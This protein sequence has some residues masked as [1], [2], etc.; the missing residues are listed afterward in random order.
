MNTSTILHELQQARLDGEI[1][2]P[3]HREYDKCRRVWNAT[4]DCL[5]TAI[6]RAKSA[7]DVEKTVTIAAQQGALLAVRGGGH[8]LPG[9][10]TCDDGI[11]L[12]LSQMNEIE[13]DESAQRVDVQAGALLGDLDRAGVPLGLVVPA[14]VVSHTGAAGLTLGGGMGWLSRRFGLTIDHLL[15]VDLVTADGR[16]RRVSA[17]TEPDLFWAI[18]GGGGNFGVVTRFVFKMNDLGPVIIG[19]WAYSTSEA[20]AVLERLNELAKTTPREV[21]TGF[22]LTPD[23]LSVVAI[24]S[25]PRASSQDAISAFGALGSTTSASLGE[26]SFLD[27]QSM[28][29]EEMAWGR[30]YYMKGLFL[31]EIDSPAIERMAQGIAEA[32]TSHTEFYVLQLG[33][34]VSDV[35]EDA[36]AY[37]GRDA[38]F[39]CLL[40]TTWD[41][42]EHDER[43][44]GWGRAAAKRMSEIAM[45]RN[46]VNEQGEAS[47][48]VA[49][50][51]YGEGK[52]ERLAKLKGRYD[53]TNLFRLNQNIEPVLEDAI[54]RF[55][56]R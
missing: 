41:D 22:V 3:K 1:V 37:S 52:Y 7:S 28:H 6:V 14:G 49:R 51:S 24:C 2:D 10:S 46:Y 8:S 39:Y 12:D 30:R 32:P 34:A 29:D 47:N 48:E 17:E 31:R 13:I 26:M 45:S 4:A 27:L 54:K 23:E 9:L 40:G 36:T 19:K 55:P 42:R 18:R 53:P 35:D 16:S 21:T 38:G 15:A 56:S 11:V 20:P 50:E 33:G 25:G 44:I 43:S 5:P